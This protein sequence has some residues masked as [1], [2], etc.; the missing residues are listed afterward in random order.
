[1]PAPPGLDRQPDHSTCSLLSSAVAHERCDRESCRRRR[2]ST[3]PGASP[4]APQYMTAWG[5]FQLK[6]RG[7]AERTAIRSSS[8]SP[9]MRWARPVGEVWS[10]APTWP[11]TTRTRPAEAESCRWFGPARVR[12]SGT[13]GPTVSSCCGR[14]RA[15][16]WQCSGRAAY[17]FRTATHL[18]GTVDGGPGASRS[19]PLRPLSAVAVRPNGATQ[20]SP[21]QASAAVRTSV[22]LG[23]LK[24]NNTKALMSA[25]EQPEVRPYGDL[26]GP[27]R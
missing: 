26:E 12:T 23:S 10:S 16:G 22:A 4:I 3:Q 11:W 2:L 20:H 9:S 5:T 13:P 8:A 17:P 1:M 24:T 21:E 19:L 7:G 6:E 14:P 18:C 25:L 15:R 27:H